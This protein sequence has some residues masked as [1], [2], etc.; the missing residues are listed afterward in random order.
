MST[1]L[2]T[3]LCTNLPEVCTSN[4]SSGLSYTNAVA[5]AEG[6]VTATSPGHIITP[7]VYNVNDYKRLIKIDDRE[8]VVIPRKITLSLYHRMLRETAYPVGLAYSYVVPFLNRA[9][10]L[11]L[12]HVSDF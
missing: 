9:L 1:D 5:P 6:L 11:R 12:I 7:Y 10:K 3:Q 8:L 2:P 4:K